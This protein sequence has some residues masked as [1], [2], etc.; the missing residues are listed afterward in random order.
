VAVECT[1]A[2]QKIILEVARQGT[3]WCFMISDS[4]NDKYIRGDNTCMEACIGAT[5]RP[6]VH[7]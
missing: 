7:T 5:R 4:L 6:A 1:I 2:D 3:S